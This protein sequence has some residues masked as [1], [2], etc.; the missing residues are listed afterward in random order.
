MFIIGGQYKHRRLATPKGNL[1]RP[2]AGRLR[3]A[4]FNICQTYIK[5][6]AFLDLFAGSGAMGLEALS[7]GARSATFVDNSQEAVRCIKRNIGDLKV[8]K[9]CEVFYG[10]AFSTLKLFE[11][12]QKTFDVIYIDPPYNTPIDIAGETFLY[13]EY[14]IHLID[15]SAL[16]IPGGTLFV[17]ED[18]RHP[19]KIATEHLELKDSRKFGHSLL[20]RY[21]RL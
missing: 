19:P 11:K 15:K 8:E 18:S 3:E 10:Q 16:L 14:I 2:T 6:A 9:E 12:Q 20:Q 5:D 21:N 7:R 4:L 17:E 13:S 1:T